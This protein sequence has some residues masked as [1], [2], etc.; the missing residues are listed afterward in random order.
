[1]T[2]KDSTPTN[3]RASPLSPQIDSS[4][5]GT[6]TDNPKQFS[7]IGF[8]HPG[9]IEAGSCPGATRLMDQAAE[10]GMSQEM[11]NINQKFESSHP[12]PTRPTTYIFQV[13]ALIM[14]FQALLTQWGVHPMR[15]SF[16]SSR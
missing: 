9:K 8:S 14:S 2:M 5:V 7:K 1:M 13:L 10:R 12:M 16:K 3:Y 11:R 4:S 15:H 6:G